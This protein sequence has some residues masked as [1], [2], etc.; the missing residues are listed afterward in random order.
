MCSRWYT[1]DSES[2]FFT[3]SGLAPIREARTESPVLCIYGPSSRP[4]FFSPHI[5]KPLAG[6]FFGIEPKNLEVYRWL[7]LFSPWPSFLETLFNQTERIT[8]RLIWWRRF[9]PPSPNVGRDPICKP[10]LVH[11]FYLLDLVKYGRQGGGTDAWL[12]VYSRYRLQ[13]EYDHIN[14]ME[15]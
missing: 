9:A 8:H 5:F 3:D 12:R 13:P 10:L 1:I 6:A 7:L 14:W 15:E 11:M 2:Y 4:A